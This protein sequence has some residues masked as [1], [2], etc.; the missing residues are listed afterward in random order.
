MMLIL[1][2][3]RKEQKRDKKSLR[4]PGSISGKATE[5]VKKSEKK[6]AKGGKADV[7]K[8]QELAG[9]DGIAERTVA[10]IP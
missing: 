2:K 4:V 8:N 7:S 3:K 9:H 10:E 5:N 6:K 1:G